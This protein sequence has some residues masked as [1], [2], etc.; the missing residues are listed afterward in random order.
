MDDQK[1]QDAKSPFFRLNISKQHYVL[2]FD[3]LLT[4]KEK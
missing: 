1:S 3:Y 2:D 4:E